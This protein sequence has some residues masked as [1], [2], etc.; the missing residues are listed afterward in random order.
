MYN[1]DYMYAIERSDDYLAHYGV[2][3]MR[4]GVRKAI[5]RRD[6][7]GLGRQYAKAQKKLAKLEKRA[8]KASKYG[9]RAALYGAGAAA[10]GL[11]AG[12]GTKLVGD[13]LGRVNRASGALGRGMDTAANAVQLAAARA[14]KGHLTSGATSAVARAGK[15]LQ[16]TSARGGGMQTAFGRISNDVTKWGNSTSI[17]DAAANAIGRNALK[18]SF[19]ATKKLGTGNIVSRA[20]FEAAN[21]A[22]KLR[23]ITNNTI[24]RVGAGAVAAGLGAAAVKNAYRAATAKKKAERFRTEMNKAFAGTQYARG[25]N[26]APRQGNRKRRRR[27]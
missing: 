26:S 3:G 5:E 17:S 20:G 6:A 9:K 14:H 1:N 18:G 8:S 11:A 12:R 27:G 10:A 22:N 24:A 19:A 25:G 4:W 2:R 15:A 7:A 21:G 13:V 23:G 16:R